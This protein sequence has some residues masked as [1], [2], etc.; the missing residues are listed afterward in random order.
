VQL[1]GCHSILALLQGFY[2]EAIELV[3]EK[4]TAAIA[5]NE[6]PN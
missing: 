4:R 6:R 1:F 2:P 5:A 3:I